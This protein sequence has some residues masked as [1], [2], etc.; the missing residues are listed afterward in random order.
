MRDRQSHE[1]PPQIILPLVSIA[2]LVVSIGVMW[3]TVTPRLPSPT[4]QSVSS[5]SSASVTDQSLQDVR[6]AIA[7]V[8]SHQVAVAHQHAVLRILV[9][10]TTF[11]SVPESGYAV[12]ATMSDLAPGQ[13]VVVQAVQDAETGALIAR[14]IVVP[15]PERRS[16]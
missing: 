16:V 8:G 3:S 10:P 7:S 9:R 12:A 4:E 13:P 1:L 6:G 2:A 5:A 15:V 11:I 14:S